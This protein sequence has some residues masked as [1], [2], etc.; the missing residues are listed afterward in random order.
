MRR[1]LLAVVLALLML[2]WHVSFA[3]AQTP[4]TRP[5]IS[6][7]VSP[8]EEFSLE[9][10]DGPP[11]V[12]VL[13]RPPGPGP[14]PAVVIPYPFPLSRWKTMALEN[15]T[16]NRFLA[17]GYVTVMQ[18]ASGERD[19][20][21]ELATSGEADLAQEVLAAR[22]TVNH[23]RNMS[24][25]DSN[26]V[27]LYGCSAGG[28]MVLQMAAETEIAA[29]IAEDPGGF[30]YESVI[31]LTMDPTLGSAEERE[32]AWFQLLTDPD[33]FFTPELRRSAQDE[34][35]KISG[36]IF[37]VQSNP[38]QELPSTDIGNEFLVPDLRAAGKEVERTIYSGQKHCF[39]FFA[40]SERGVKNDG[41]AAA[42]RLFADM[43]AFFKRHLPT[44]P[45]AVGESLVELVPIE[46][47]SSDTVREKVA[48][49]VSS[50]ILADYVGLYEVVP[51][52][53]FAV[54][55]EEGQLMVQ[56][57]GWEKYSLVAESET[58]FFLKE[59]NAVLEFVRGEDGI[60][61][62]L[63]THQGSFERTLTRK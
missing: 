8:V 49:T 43:D 31:A 12:G 39:G 2:C 51:G 4:V 3:T 61:T 7:E 41:D 59:E 25:V 21:E 37:L 33:Q 27:V 16:M 55:L 45:Q 48:I 15:A 36:P 19:F 10:Q 62:H 44:Q 26:S 57:T 34:F 54:T 58:D 23:V 35:R 46:P 60:V 11:A 9:M 24:D 56:A 20:L 5:V 63:I 14:F 28:Y 22:A 47:V 50:E 53:D 52:L 42:S 1:H 30:G 17:A 40:T 6:E 38:G 32:A 18:A 29:V 13:R